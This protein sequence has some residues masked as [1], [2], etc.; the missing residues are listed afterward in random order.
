MAESDKT[1]IG[2]MLNDAMAYHFNKQAEKLQEWEREL[3]QKDLHGDP[4]LFDGFHSLIEKDMEQDKVKL[5]REEER[6]LNKLSTEALRQS[7]EDGLA[8][9]VVMNPDR[10]FSVL[11][12]TKN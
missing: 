10:S 6:E 9:M 2:Q 1:G 11:T 7:N 4:K 5:T 3:I 8:R 12:E